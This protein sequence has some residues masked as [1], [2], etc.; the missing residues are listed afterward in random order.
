MH[1]SLPMKR[2]ESQRDPPL[3]IRVFGESDRTPAPTLGGQISFGNLR[4][5]PSLPPSIHVTL[6]GLTCFVP[7][8]GT[9]S[10]PDVPIRNAP[11]IL[12]G[13]RLLSPS[14][15]FLF[16]YNLR[17]HL[18]CW[19][20]PLCFNFVNSCGKEEVSEKQPWS[21][22]LFSP[23]LISQRESALRLPSLLQRSGNWPTVSKMLASTV[24]ITPRARQLTSARASAPSCGYAS[25]WPM[26]SVQDAA[27]PPRTHAPHVRASLLNR[28]SAASAEFL[29][30]APC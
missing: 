30:D 1:V 15:R 8:T 10:L 22:Q 25:G 29:R 3:F 24:A 4:L 13:H 17:L 21:W 23:K 11:D 12:V 18:S 2:G 28:T 20:W 14:G 6:V 19:R 9:S 7:S 16:Q 5:S 27:A 26:A